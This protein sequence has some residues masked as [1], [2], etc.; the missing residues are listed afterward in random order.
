M[1]RGPGSADSLR[2]DP[3]VYETLANACFDCHSDR[4]SGFW[5]AKFAPSYLFGA[6]K[7][8]DA[9]NFSNWAAMDVKQR[10][11]TASLIAA[12][13]DSG[14][15][16]PGDYDFFHSSARLSDE[17]KKLVHQWASQQVA[18]AAH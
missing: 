6:Q 5:S 17:Q 15:M 14:S 4:G 16:P 1:E 10:S 8:R 12:V 3:Q 18:L 2:A 7:G 9:L 13:V 11:A